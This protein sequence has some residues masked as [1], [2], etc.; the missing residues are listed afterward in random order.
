MTT[1]NVI[2]SGTAAWIACLY[3]LKAD[4]IVTLHRDPDAIVRRIGESTVPTINEIPRLI[5][6]SEDEFLNKVD[7]YYKYGTIF[8]N[9][10]DDD[11][12]LYYFA[13]EPDNL[14]TDS[15][16]TYAYHID[17]RGFC[18]VL[19]TYCSSQPNF[20]LINSPF[21]LDA[22]S[23][24]EFYVD[25][26]GQ[27]GVL[28]EQVN[29]K[30]IKSD[31]LINDFAVIGNDVPSY[32]P[33]TKSQALSCG[34]LWSI[35]LRSRMS[36]GYVF[37]SNYISKEDAIKEF[38][39]YT[40][41][42]H[43]GVIGFETRI[44]EESWK[45]NVLFLG[46]SAGF[47]EPLNAT[48]NFA[49]QS[50]IKNFLKLEHNQAAYNRLMKKTHVGIHKW[51]K[52]LYSCNTRSGEYWDYYKNNRDSALTDIDYYSTHGHQ[53]LMGKHSWT[54]LKDHML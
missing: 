30:H 51:I 11:S 5:G 37:S 27:N 25:A 23:A 19:Q 13:N 45:E 44:P 9:W 17:A 52:S 42:P 46:L 15:H 6:M 4:K 48:A 2:G 35:S 49:A 54:L 16:Q 40:G 22:Y 32:Q 10:K 41:I 50:G 36:Y 7:G 26:S 29:L 14:A 34:W 1:Y 3:L 39:E 20:T 47:V 21:T 28:S 31:F 53:G 24:S 12:W 8:S 43:E 33:Y 18:N 38:E